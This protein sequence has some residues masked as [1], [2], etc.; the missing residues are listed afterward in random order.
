MTFRKFHIRDFSLIFQIFIFITIIYRMKKN[1]GKHTPP[2]QLPER[3]FGEALHRCVFGGCCVFG[4]AL[5]R[6]IS[7]EA[8]RFFV[9]PSVKFSVSA[10]QSISYTPR[11]SSEALCRCISD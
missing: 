2:C 7:G 6:C 4:E 11:V 1:D 10:P 8:L 5:H 9:A 3:I